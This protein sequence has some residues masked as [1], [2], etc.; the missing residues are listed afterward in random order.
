MLNENAWGP[1]ES[2]TT[3]HAHMDCIDPFINT[4][5]IETIWGYIHIHILF[6]WGLWARSRGLTMC[7]RVM[8]KDLGQPYEWAVRF[9]R[10]SPSRAQ[11]SSILDCLAVVHI[12]EGNG[13]PLQYSCLETPMDGGAW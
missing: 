5:K 4:L 7:F 8:A 10:P 3:E 12:G 13:T 11:D 9:R 6:T 2:D 1:K